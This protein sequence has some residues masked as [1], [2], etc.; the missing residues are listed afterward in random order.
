MRM[1]VCMAPS[2]TCTL[3]GCFHLC[4][5]LHACSALF[6]G[7]FFCSRFTC[8]TAHAVVSHSLIAAADPMNHHQ[9]LTF[10]L[11]PVLFTMMNRSAL[12]YGRR[13]QSQHLNNLL[14][15][16]CKKRATAMDSLCAHLCRKDTV[17]GVSDA[18]A[19]VL[20]LAPHIDVASNAHCCIV[21]EPHRH[22]CDPVCRHTLLIA[23]VRLPLET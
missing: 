6:R 3:R 9:H 21:I 16:S 14:S 7:T 20:V 13:M 4:A 2:A 10:C 5:P 23:G 22:R 8:C 18:Q 17:E 12:R 1:S 15:D 11:L 19:S